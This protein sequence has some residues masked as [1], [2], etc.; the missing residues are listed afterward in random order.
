M[1]AGAYLPTAVECGMRKTV[2]TRYG[3]SFQGGNARASAGEGR[4]ASGHYL[5]CIRG[6]FFFSIT[7]EPGVE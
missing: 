3:R 4:P 2:V 7:L 6:E 5:D 1:L